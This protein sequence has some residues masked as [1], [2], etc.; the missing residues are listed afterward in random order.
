MP[1]A[2]VAEEAGFEPAWPIKDRP[3]SNQVSYQLLNSSMQ[4]GGET[5]I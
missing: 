4:T 5:G 2:S 3:I 1:N